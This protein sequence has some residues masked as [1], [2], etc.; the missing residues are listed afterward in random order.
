[1]EG[2]NTAQVIE[3]MR[4]NRNA[5]ALRP[6]IFAIRFVLK[7]MTNPHE[8]AK[9]Q[10]NTDKDP[11]EEHAI[12]QAPVKAPTATKKQGERKKKNKRQSVEKEQDDTNSKGSDTNDDDDDRE[13]DAD[14]I[15]TDGDDAEEHDSDAEHDDDNKSGQKD[16][17]R[18]KTSRKELAAPT[19]DEE[20]QETNKEKCQ[21]KAGAAF[22]HVKKAWNLLKDRH[23]QDIRP[24]A[25]HIYD[26]LDTESMTITF[27]DGTEDKKIKITKEAIHKVFGYPNGTEKSAQRPEKSP[28]SMKELMSDLGFK[29]TN[30]KPKELFRELKIFQA[31]KFQA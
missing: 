12:Q 1:M 13:H 30:F 7:A 24:L 25:A 19:V 11:A 9:T 10:Q 27:G 29:H 31:Y 16:R 5:T 21:I 8:E 26:N 15:P 23:K 3:E 4:F 28:T 17:K 6:G 18:R 14:F 22:A 20:Q 2:K